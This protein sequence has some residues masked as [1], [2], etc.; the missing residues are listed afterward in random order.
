MEILN[1]ANYTLLVKMFQYGEKELLAMMH[2]LLKRYYKQIYYNKD[3]YLIAVGEDTKIG[4]VAHCDTVFYKQPSEE[5]IYYDVYRNVLWSPEGLGAD[6]RAGLFIILKLLQYKM[7]PTVILTLGEESGG[8][9]AQELIKAFPHNEFDLK[10]L[11]QLDRR[12]SNDCVFYSCDNKEFTKK[13]ESYGFCEKQGTFTDISYIAPAWGIA[14][15]NLSVGYQDEHTRQERLYISDMIQ[16]LKKVRTILKDEPTLQKYEYIESQYKYSSFCEVSYLAENCASCGEYVDVAYDGI[17]VY[18]KE[19]KLVYY[20]P[21]CF[22]KICGT[23]HWC[24]GCGMPF[25][26]DNENNLCTGCL[27][28]E[29]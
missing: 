2:N 23:L 8:L 29:V 5:D 3:H 27:N 15:C 26:G 10:F 28:G 19:G 24:Y 16:T 4:V 13:I 18:N 12:G 21:E 1:K 9:G 25:L 11:I 7:R 6:D 20:C 22:S 14:A 17:P